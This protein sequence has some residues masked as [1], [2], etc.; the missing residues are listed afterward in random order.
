MQDHTE[1][2]RDATRIVHESGAGVLA[3]VGADHQPHA[4]WMGGVGAKNGLDEVLTITAPHTRK[5]SNL[6]ENPRAEWMF[7]SPTKE[8]IVYLSGPTELITQSPECDDLWEEIPNKSQAYF[9]KYYEVAKGF[10][11]IRT[12]VERV[13]VVK[14]LVFKKIVLRE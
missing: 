9:L 7:S 8:T 12:K 11:V 13:E 1:L 2:W 6:R 3:T 5:V 4:T 14:P 10:A